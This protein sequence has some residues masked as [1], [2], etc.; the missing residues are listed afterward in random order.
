[1]Y[2][3]LIPMRMREREKA[4]FQSGVCKKLKYDERKKERI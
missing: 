1:M 4:V 3:K 2:S